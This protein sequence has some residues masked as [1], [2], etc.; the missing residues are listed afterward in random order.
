[1]ESQETP[2]PTGL[3]NGPYHHAERILAWFQK[4]YRRL[5]IRRERLTICFTAFLVLATIH[6][7]TKK[8]IV[9]EIHISSVA[10]TSYTWPASA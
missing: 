4:K 9:K 10:A 2:W 8:L 1:V 5:V 7:C 3:D 6:I